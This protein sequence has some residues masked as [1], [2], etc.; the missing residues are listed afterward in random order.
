M[1]GTVE[2]FQIGDVRAALLVKPPAP[3]PEPFHGLLITAAGRFDL[4][5]EPVAGP[6]EPPRF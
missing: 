5:R 4:I 3:L 2:T 1:S 6:I